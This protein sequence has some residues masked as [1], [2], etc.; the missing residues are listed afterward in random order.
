[1][2]GEITML[3]LFDVLIFF[4]GFIF[5]FFLCSI[6]TSGKVEDAL[7][8]GFNEGLKQGRKGRA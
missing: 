4:A 1:V 5:G 8:H 6:F 7:R 3:I 2:V